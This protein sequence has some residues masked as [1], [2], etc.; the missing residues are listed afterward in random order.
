MIE[1]FAFTSKVIYIIP[2]KS[3]YFF[4]KYNKICCLSKN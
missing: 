4:I 3:R 2:V 1:V